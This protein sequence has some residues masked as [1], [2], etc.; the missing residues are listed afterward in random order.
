MAMHTRKLRCSKKKG[1]IKH[2]EQTGSPNW[3]LTCLLVEKQQ[4][5]LSGMGATIKA[6]PIT[7]Q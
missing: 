1:F 3:L 4:K 7:G 2:R 5:L 6:G